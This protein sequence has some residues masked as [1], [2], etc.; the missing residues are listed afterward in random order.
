[1]NLPSDLKSELHQEIMVDTTTPLNI[2]LFVPTQKEM[3]VI[4][5]GAHQRF[6]DKNTS[7]R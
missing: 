3:F 1:V 6:E 4:M 5:L 7:G 2:D